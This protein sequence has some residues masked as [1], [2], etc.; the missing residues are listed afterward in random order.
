MNRLAIG[1]NSSY[2]RLSI[3]SF[4]IDNK[5]D[6]ANIA[7]EGLEEEPPPETRARM[8]ALGFSILARVLRSIS[9][10]LNLLNYSSVVR[11]S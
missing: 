1:A 11:V 10:D 4:V 5:E 8:G 2:T 3:Y 6:K 9:V 7:S